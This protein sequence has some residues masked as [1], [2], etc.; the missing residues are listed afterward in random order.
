MPHLLQNNVQ[1]TIKNSEDIKHFNYTALAISSYK[2]DICDPGVWIQ[3]LQNSQNVYLTFGLPKTL[4]LW[5]FNLKIL[6]VVF[7]PKLHKAE[8]LAKYLQV[9]CTYKISCSRT[10]NIWSRT[11]TF[12]S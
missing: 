10:F 9:D 6:S 2:R 11:D 8:N 1:N 12:C 4:V 5:H 3:N 7:D